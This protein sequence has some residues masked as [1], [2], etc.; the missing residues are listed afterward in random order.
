MSSLVHLF[1]YCTVLSQVCKQYLN[2]CLR[3]LN[4]AYLQC[5]VYFITS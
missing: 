2:F 3:P 5:I 4:F 1:S